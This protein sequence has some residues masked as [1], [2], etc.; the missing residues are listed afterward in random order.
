MRRKLV[1]L[2]LI[3]SFPLFSLAQRTITGKVTASTGGG[4]I[5]GVN[6]VVEGNATTGATTNG[7]GNLFY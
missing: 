6:I 2:L 7:D 5:S 3:I 4:A 1:Y